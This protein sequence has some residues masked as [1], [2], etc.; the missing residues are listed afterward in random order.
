VGADGAEPVRV[1]DKEPPGRLSADGRR[2]GLLPGGAGQ[3]LR[4]QVVEPVLEL[5]VGGL[6]HLLRPVAGLADRVPADPLVSALRE[7]QPGDPLPVPSRGGPELR[8]GQHFVRQLA[9]QPRP[10]LLA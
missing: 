7:G 9:G 5:S 10:L 4:G 2:A 3:Q 8:I 6:G 1:R